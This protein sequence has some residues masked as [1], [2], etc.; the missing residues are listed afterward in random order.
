MH[1]AILMVIEKKCAVYTG[2]YGSHF[3]LFM[4]RN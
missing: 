3:N 1:T 2:K 4:D